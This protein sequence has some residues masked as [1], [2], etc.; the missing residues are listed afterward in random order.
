MQFE[1]DMDK[2]LLNLAEARR[3]I[4]RGDYSRYKQ[5][6]NVVLPHRDVAQGCRNLA[7]VNEALRRV[8]L[9]ASEPPG[10]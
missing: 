10:R 5:G 1:W 9:R 6:N 3:F 4:R 7:T 2:V 8:P